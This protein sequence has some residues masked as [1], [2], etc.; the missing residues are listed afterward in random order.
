[1]NDSPWLRGAEVLDALRI[2]PRVILIAVYAFTLWYTWD[3]T[4]F[5][6]GLINQPQV[7]E[8]K[9]AA[10]TAFGS[11]TIGAICA[12]AAG[13]TKSYMDSGRKWNGQERR[14]S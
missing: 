6:Y 11:L 9:L 10:Y 13:I 4:E 1:M 8:M 7:S 14:D 2:I 5:F 3:F 12:L